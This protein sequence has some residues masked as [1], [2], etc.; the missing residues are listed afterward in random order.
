MDRLKTLANTD[1]SGNVISSYTYQRNA[2]G[3][4]TEVDEARTQVA[5]RTVKYQYDALERLTSETDIVGTTSATTSYTYDLVGNRSTQTDASGTT[6]FHYTADDQ[7]QTETAPGGTTVTTDYYDFN[8]SLTSTTVATTVNGTTTT[9]TTANYIYDARGRLISATVNGQQE[10]F[11]YDDDGNQVSSTTAASGTTVY[12]KEKG[13][14]PFILSP[15]FSGL[16]P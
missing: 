14:G 9:T 5:S 1:G 4:I 13:T 12:E 15:R 6:T 3:D 10:S 2:M 16:G 11:N 8:G 7:L